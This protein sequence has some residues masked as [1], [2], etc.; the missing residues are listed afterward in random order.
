MFGKAGL[1][2]LRLARQDQKYNPHIVHSRGTVRT[3]SY[4]SERNPWVY[5]LALPSVN[6]LM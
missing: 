3:T 1:K 4:T 6:A 5:M 2:S